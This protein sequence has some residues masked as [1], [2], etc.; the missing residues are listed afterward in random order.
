MHIR[1]YIILHL[2]LILLTDNLLKSSSFTCYLQTEVGLG[3]Q[4]IQNPQ[5][6]K[7]LFFVI[8]FVR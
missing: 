3:H 4:I 7:H 6:N 1:L 8:L 5:L 2:R